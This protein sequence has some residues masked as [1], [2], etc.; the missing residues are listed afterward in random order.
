MMKHFYSVK[1]VIFFGQASSIFDFVERFALNL[2]NFNYSSFIIV[3]I[4]IKSIIRREILGKKYRKRVFRLFKFSF[5][6]FGFSRMF[7]I[8]LNAFVLSILLYNPS[9]IIIY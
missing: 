6:Y 9:F 3:I 7:C 5:V 2:I 1:K 4:V 8:K